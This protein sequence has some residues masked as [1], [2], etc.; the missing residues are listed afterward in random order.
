MDLFPY[1]GLLVNSYHGDL[2][3]DSFFNDHAIGSRIRCLEESREESEDQAGSD[4]SQQTLV[5]LQL[6]PHHPRLDS[7]P[8]E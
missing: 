7:S 3:L 1:H 5:D 2:D 6:N 4:R 8:P